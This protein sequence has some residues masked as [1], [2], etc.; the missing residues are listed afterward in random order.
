VNLWRCSRSIRA[1][2]K[3]SYHF[4]ETLTRRFLH[5]R[6]ESLSRS[7]LRGW[8]IENCY[9]TRQNYKTCRHVDNADVS[10]WATTRILPAVN[11]MDEPRLFSWWRQCI[12][13]NSLKG[14][15]K[16]RLAWKLFMKGDLEPVILYWFHH[17][18]LVD[19]EIA[20]KF[21]VAVLC[22]VSS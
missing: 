1:R 4:S 14:T 8:V 13:R 3:Y 16:L 18:V 7:F 19:L 9:I 5:G 15:V 2:A 17:E 12:I 22:A 21:L 10:G 20:T 11:E 6:W